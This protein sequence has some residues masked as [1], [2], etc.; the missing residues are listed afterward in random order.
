LHS[1][2]S[3]AGLSLPSSNKL[4]VAGQHF[5]TFFSHS[6]KFCRSNLYIMKFVSAILL[7]FAGSA[8]AAPAAQRVDKVFAG[9]ARVANFE[10][11]PESGSRLEERGRG[12]Y[13]NV[14]IPTLR[15]C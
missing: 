12:T 15:L 6:V 14:C 2:T 9:Q 1:H 13:Y 10:A 3:K 5:C 11:A 4:L 8:M 7:A